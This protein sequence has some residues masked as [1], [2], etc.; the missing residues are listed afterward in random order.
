M[1]Q[2]RQHSRARPAGK[3]QDARVRIGGEAFHCKHTASAGKQ[4]ACGKGCTQVRS[5]ASRRRGLPCINCRAIQP[6]KRSKE[7]HRAQ[8][9]QRRDGPQ[10]RYA[11]QRGLCASQRK[12]HA[13]Q[14]FLRQQRR[15]ER[16]SSAACVHAGEVGKCGCRQHKI[17][18]TRRNRHEKQDDQSSAAGRGYGECQQ[19][20]TMAPV[21][22]M[23]LLQVGAACIAQPH[24]RIQ[25]SI[26][27]IHRPH[28]QCKQ[29]RNPQRQMHVRHP[30]KA[31]RPDDCNRRSVKACQVP[32]S[33]RPRC[34]KAS[35]GRPLPC[36][37]NGPDYFISHRRIGDRQRQRIN[38]TGNDA[39]GPDRDSTGDSWNEIRNLGG[40]LA[41]AEN[42]PR[43]G[44][45]LQS[46]PD[47]VQ[48]AAVAFLCATLACS[49]V[50]SSAGMAS[51][52][53]FPSASCIRNSWLENAE[54]SLKTLL[55]RR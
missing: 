2:P 44:Q 55:A 36:S 1:I 39:L 52:S 49:L 28:R 11:P 35:R 6:G 20:L 8:N 30:A 13:D 53:T 14:Q 33:H 26:A 42:G 19:G 12:Q 16:V 18:L 21:K 24:P 31:D 27:D 40:R 3:Q 7:D 38:F 48:S 46:I 50:F 17:L 15:Q 10:S 25:Q 37:V 45:P 47:P 34:V 9:R 32:E 43:D 5:R 22:I 54:A 4:A 41:E 51:R 29:H 23:P